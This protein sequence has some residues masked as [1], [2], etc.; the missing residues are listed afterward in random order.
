MGLCAHILSKTYLIAIVSFHFNIL[1]RL[2]MS[3]SILPILHSHSTIIWILILLLLLSISLLIIL[4]LLLLLLLLLTILINHLLLLLISISL[5]RL[6]LLFII[7]P[8]INC[9]RR[10]IPILLR[11]ALCTTWLI[12]LLLLVIILC[13]IIVLIIH[14]ILILSLQFILLLLRLLRKPCRSL[15]FTSL[16]CQ[17]RILLS[18]NLIRITI[19]KQIDALLPLHFAN[20]SGIAT[21]TQQFSRQQPKH[22]TDREFTAI[23]AWNCHIDKTRVIV[24]STQ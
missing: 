7:A 10:H 2:Q 21:H 14:R 3:P 1:H 5:L 20:T 23:I 19:K 22:E 24:R 15:L 11:I 9:R 6:R 17:L 8:I 4:L 12:I 13:T 18:L 16:F